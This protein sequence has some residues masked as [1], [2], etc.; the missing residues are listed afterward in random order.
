[1][2]GTAGLSHMRILDEITRIAA[3]VM[4]VVLENENEINVDDAIQAMSQ[5]REG[6]IIVLNN[7]ELG[8]LQLSL[9]TGAKWPPML[10]DL[11][12]HYLRVFIALVR[13]IYN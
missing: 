2:S 10:R 6:V 3:K 4:P 13:S 11:D 5:L 8:G 12:P 9:Y 7:H 1:M